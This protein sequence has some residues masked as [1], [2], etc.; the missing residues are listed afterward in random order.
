MMEIRAKIKKELNIMDVILLEPSEDLR[1]VIR[2][3]LEREHA[4]VYEV[5]TSYQVLDCLTQYPRIKVLMIDF[6]RDPSNTYDLLDELMQTGH[7]DTLNL[8]VTS[9][10]DVT[11]AKYPTASFLR[12]PYE[13]DDLIRSLHRPSLAY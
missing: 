1:N 8:I 7:L 11:L 3:I 10:Y 12:K 2:E 4:T 5:A 6:D 13:M 9:A